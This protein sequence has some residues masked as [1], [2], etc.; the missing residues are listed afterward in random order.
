M[1]HTPT[2]CPTWCAGRNQHT[3]DALRHASKSVRVGTQNDA[4]F[5]HAAYVRLIWWSDQP[6][7]LVHLARLRADASGDSGVRMTLADAVSWA[8]I[9]DGVG[10]VELAAAIRGVVALAEVQ[11]AP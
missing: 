8:D 1:T 9:L 11:A 2:G 4:L 5:P 3:I 10:A 6:D 7:P